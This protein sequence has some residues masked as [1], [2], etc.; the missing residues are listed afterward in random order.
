MGQYTIR[1]T[2]DCI[3]V[4]FPQ[5]ITPELAEF[6]G[7]M[8]GDGHLA[9]GPRKSKNGNPYL[10][11]KVA[12]ACNSEESQYVS[13]LQGLFESLFSSS[14]YKIRDKRSKCLILQKNSK[15]IAKFLKYSCGLP[16]NN[17]TNSLSI[18]PIILDGSGKIKCA[19][20]RGLADTD[21][22][23]LFKNKNKSY[24]T[25]PVIKATFRGKKIIDGIRRLYDD[26]GFTYCVVYEEKSY[27]KRQ[28]RYEYKNS[29]YLNGRGNLARWMKKIGFSNYKNLAK[30]RKWHA[31]GFCPPGYKAPDA[32]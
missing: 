5:K 21:F 1:I 20:L 3:D 28:S 30:F 17:K 23:L 27:D 26:L 24:H 32:I 12:I 2:E 19:F 18:P 22:S 25:Y 11:Y 14:L 8:I 31:D 7:I 4:S 10:K 13:F 29:I 15:P 16:T 6:L 9:F